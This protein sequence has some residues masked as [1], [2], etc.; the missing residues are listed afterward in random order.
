[1]QQKKIVGI[2]L[3]LVL[4]LGFG[5]DAVCQN[6][7][8]KKIISTPGFIVF[9]IPNK[10]TC[11]GSGICGISQAAGNNAIP[12]TFTATQIF[13]DVTTNIFDLSIS[14]SLAALRDSHQAPEE[15]VMFTNSTAANKAYPMGNNV[16]SLPDGIM[17]A[18]GFP[19]GTTFTI[20]VGF[21]FFFPPNTAADGTITQ[22][23]I[24]IHIGTINVMHNNPMHGG[25]KKPTKK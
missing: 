22:D 17:T 3:S 4:S 18:L 24:T 5:H 1:M 9:G 8:G 2:I 10:L 21:K 23:Q 7:K 12:V 15:F 6:A 20:P 19:L 25:T 14:F 11:S 16:I 13:F